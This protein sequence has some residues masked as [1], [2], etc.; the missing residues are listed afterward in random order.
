[1][2]QC[3]GTE[4]REVG[5]GGWVEE[6]THRYTGKEDGIEGFCGGGGGKGDNI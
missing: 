6:H 5:V 4:G 2:S 3:R 1:M